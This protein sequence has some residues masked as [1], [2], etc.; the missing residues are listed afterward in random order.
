MS[1]QSGGSQIIIDAFYDSYKDSNKRYNIGHLDNYLVVYRYFKECR[2][3]IVHSG[4]IASQNLLA[5]QTNY[6]S[7]VKE[8]ID[9]VEIPRFIPSTL[10]MPVELSL[11]G[12]VGFT[13]VILN[14]V[15]TLDIEFIKCKNVD[16]VFLESIKNSGPF[17]VLTSTKLEKKKNDIIHIC[18]RASFR[19]PQEFTNLH[20][21][22]YRNGIVL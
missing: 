2:N 5:A 19:P 14:I 21:F 1:L 13:Q 17:P 3:S 9:V 7:L 10:G 11:R 15:S 6:Q 16:T 20:G 12:V 8:D 18:G 22:L 4:G